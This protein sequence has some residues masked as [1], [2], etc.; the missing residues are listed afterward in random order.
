[1]ERI[2]QKHILIFL[3][4]LILPQF[5]KGQ[6][7]PGMHKKVE[8]PHWADTL[9]N[10]FKSYTA[11]QIHKAKYLYDQHCAVCHGKKGIGNGEAGFGLE[12]P[13]NDLTEKEMQESSDGALFWEI[14]FGIAPMSGYSSRLTEAERWLIIQYVRKLQADRIHSNKQIQKD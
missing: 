4:I 9:T 2:L 5:S 6:E 3:S 11:E 1:M 10:P 8:V 7:H 14:S 13:P 12:P